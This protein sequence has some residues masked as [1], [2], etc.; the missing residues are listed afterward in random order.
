MKSTRKTRKL[1]VSVLIFML[2]EKIQWFCSVIVILHLI[3]E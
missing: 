2:L 1:K 3:F